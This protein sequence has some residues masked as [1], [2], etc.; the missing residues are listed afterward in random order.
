MNFYTEYELLEPLPG[1]SVKSFKAR[2]IKTM[3]DVRVHLLV[4]GNEAVVKQVKNLAPEKRPMILDQGQHEG[5]VYYVT[6]PL[7]DNAGFEQWLTAPVKPAAP[8]LGRVG[9]P[10]EDIQIPLRRQEGRWRVV[11]GLKP[12]VP[13]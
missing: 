8:D 2:H 6:P 9:Q 3:R 13:E 1:G 4:G 7:P 11:L 5:T 10:R 12:T